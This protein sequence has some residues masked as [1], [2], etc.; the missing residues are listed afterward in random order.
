M[1][2]YQCQNCNHPVYFENVT[3]ESCQTWLG[4]V[5]AEDK[6]LALSPGGE[7]WLVAEA[8]NRPYKYCSNHVHHVCNWM[9]PADDPTGLCTACVLNHTIPNLGNL[10]QLEEWRRLEKAKHRLVYALQRMGL[11]V[12]GKDEAPYR[13]LAFDFLADADQEDPVMTGHDAGLI[14]LN[15]AEANSVHRE[16]TRLA[17]KERYRTLIGHFRHEVGH[18]YWDLLVAE[19]DFTLTAFRNLFGDERADYGE[20]LEQHYKN[21]PRQDWQRHFISSYATAHPWEDW[22]ETWA[23][24]LHLMDMLETAHAFGLSLNPPLGPDQM[25]NIEASFDPYNESEMDKILKACI[26][27]TFAVNSLN[28][29]MGRPDLYPFVVNADVRNKLKFVHKVVRTANR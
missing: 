7:T 26:P 21:G 10:R 17:M 19:N 5:D 11:P 23:H 3:C 20:A 28:R 14:T 24:Y 12:I 16:A 9:I 22:A 15:T 18:Y 8:G 25:M 13:G 2:I 27:L 4:Y 29:G 6:M 1:K